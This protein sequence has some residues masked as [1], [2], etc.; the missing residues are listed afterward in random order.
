MSKKSILKDKEGNGLA[1]LTLTSCV[2]D[3][4]GRSLA[5]VLPLIEGELENF[6]KL[7]RDVLKKDLF[8]DLWNYACGSY[9]RYNEDTGYF[10]LNGLTDI[11]YE[12]AIKIY[13]AGAITKDA[14]VF[15]RTND[16]IRTNLPSLRNV[17]SEGTQAFYGCH[18][19]EVVNA[20]NVIAGVTMLGG[21]NKLHTVLNM[22]SLNRDGLAQGA[23]GISTLVNLYGSIRYKG[24]IDLKNCAKLSYSSFRHMVDN[25]VYSGP[26]TIDVSVHQG[27]Y[28]ALTG[29]A[30]YPFNGGTQEEWNQ[31]LLD[32]QTKNITFATA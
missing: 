32:A 19:I 13:A 25:K 11:T 23:F 28:D 10:E 14:S 15:Y 16:D 24:S 8:I 2:F 17:Q 6:G 30:S 9:G 7:T 22:Y 12:Q 31:V 1:P 27:V 21:N 4:K 26:E 29:S 5:Q 20:T 3:D 18:N